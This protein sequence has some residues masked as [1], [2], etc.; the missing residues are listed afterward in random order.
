MGA[1]AHK[2]GTLE[3]QGEVQGGEGE[4][5][6]VPWGQV[7]TRAELWR[8]RERCRVGRGKRGGSH[9]GRCAQERNFGD[10]G[11][12]AGWGGGRG[13]GP[14]GAGA[15][16]SGTLEMQGEV[17]GGEGEEGWVPWGQVRTRA[18]LWRCRERCREGRGKRGGS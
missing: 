13:V 9:G 15:H 4:E 5:G 2:S 7:R 3:M 6:W 11:R 10:A 17:Q 14:M 8:C 16:K 18:E 1:G 12:G